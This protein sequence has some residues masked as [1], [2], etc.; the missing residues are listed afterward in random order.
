MELSVEPMVGDS[1]QTLQEKY[2]GL[3]EEELEV[4]YWEIR[5]LHA[6]AK[7]AAAKEQQGAAGFRF[8]PEAEIL[9]D[10]QYVTTTRGLVEIS[11][12]LHPEVY[13]LRD[14]FL[15]LYARSGLRAVKDSIPGI[16][17]SD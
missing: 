12:F 10:Y 7:M 3:S 8:T 17:H 13:D 6:R 2:Q 5:G 1:S 14:E 15:W 11:P 16:M 4:R 9:Q